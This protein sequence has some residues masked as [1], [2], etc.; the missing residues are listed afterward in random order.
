M[1]AWR[2]S[3]HRAV[4]KRKRP[5]LVLGAFAAGVIVAGGGYLA[6]T[7][8]IRIMRASGAA[9]VLDTSCPSTLPAAVSGCTEQAVPTSQI[10]T[11]SGSSPTASRTMPATPLPSASARA[12]S[13]GPM[14]SATEPARARTESAVKQVLSLIN[15]ARAQA[16]LPAYTLTTGLRRSAGRHNATMADGCGLSHRCPGEPSLGARETAAGVPWMTAGENIGEGGPVADSSAMIAQMA[17]VL[18]QDML[19]E[20]PPSDGHRQNILSSSFH[21]IGIAIRRDPSGTVWMTQDFS[22]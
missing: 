5:A 21:H 1:P 3:R 19:N 22:N 16:G 18:T 12:A 8:T 14:P 17:V 2:S 15:R 6:T 7:T 10:S 11:L 4:R 13:P 20:T 9:G